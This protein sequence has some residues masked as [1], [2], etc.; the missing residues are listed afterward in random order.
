MIQSSI[1]N[2]DHL[3]RL[4]RRKD[5][6]FTGHFF[7]VQFNALNYTELRK[8]ILHHRAPRNSAARST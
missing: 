1:G 8:T 3:C 5:F 7:I 2:A 6:C 4:H